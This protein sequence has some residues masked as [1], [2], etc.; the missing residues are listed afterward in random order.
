MS[1]LVLG[2]T[3]QTSQV[4]PKEVETLALT[5]NL[6]I[7]QSELKDWA[8]LLTGLNHCA[9][10]VLAIPDYYPQVDLA[11]Y[12][13]TNIYRPVGDKETDYGGWAT[14]A[15]IKCTQ[16]KS[17]ELKGKTFA[18]KDAIAVAGIQC[19]NGI[20]GKVGEWVPKVDAAL[21]TR[22]L[23]AGG[24][25]LGKS[26]CEA[27]CLVAVSDTSITGN[28][29]NPYAYG[30]ST[31]GSSSGSARLVSTGQVDM[32]IGTD[33]GGSTR[34]PSANCGVVGLK[35]TWGLVPYTGCL[36]LEATLDHVGPIARIVK[37]CATLL[38]VIAGNDGID[39]RQP[40]NWPQGHV[41][42]GE[43]LKK[44][45][46]G[47]AASETP[48]KGI[49]VGILEEGFPAAMTDPNVAAASRS[50]I[51][52]LEELGAEVKEISIPFY[53]DSGRIWMVD[54]AMVRISKSCFAFSRTLQELQTI[55]NFQDLAYSHTPQRF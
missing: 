6:T 12:P 23:D 53:K 33:Q 14:K 4:S 7:P 1:V 35:P 49:K 29:H 34:K 37:D 21:V 16:P 2:E 17:N 31:G 32:A 24:V 40:Y 39:D 45:T 47:S 25:I 42:F 3:D 41:K 38:E 54:M 46:E 9:E 43:E 36:S 10:E 22:I 48:L 11:L 44:F 18:I 26:A 19:T 13:R 30:Y 51:S 15:I 27:G 50:A 55:L 8:V 52:K 20:G 28:V 5:N